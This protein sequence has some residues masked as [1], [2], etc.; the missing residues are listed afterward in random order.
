[1]V[2]DKQVRRLFLEMNKQQSK[3]LAAAKSGMDEKTARKYVREGKLPSQLKKPRTYRTRKDPFDWVSEE[4]QPLLEQNPGLEAKQLFQHLQRKYPGRFSDGQLRSFQ[5]KKMGSGKY[6]VNIYPD[7]VTGYLH[8][9]R[10][11]IKHLTPSFYTLTRDY[12]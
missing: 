11:E 3:S 8:D 4:C 9:Q 5:R 1:M 2:T 7:H 6:L 12:S 10:R